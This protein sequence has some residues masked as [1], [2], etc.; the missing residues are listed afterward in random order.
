MESR[1]GVTNHAARKR[2]P[3]GIMNQMVIKRSLTIARN[4]KSRVWCSMQKNR[5]ASV[6][7]KCPQD[8][9][10]TLVYE[11]IE[12]ICRHYEKLSTAVLVRASSRGQ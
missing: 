4:D 1:N 9:A 12:T 2:L 7:L 11:K 10:V 5:Q 3:S 8:S 6:V